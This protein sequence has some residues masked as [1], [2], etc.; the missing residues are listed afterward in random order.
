MLEQKAS[1]EDQ[2]AR[3][4]GG[5][6]G[7]G[8]LLVGKSLEKEA[9]R[10]LGDEGLPSKLP[11]WGGWACG[12]QSPE[13]SGPPGRTARPGSRSWAL[14]LVLQSVQVGFQV[15][16]DQRGVGGPPEAR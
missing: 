5:L 2:G 15:A 13:V 3:E 12:G 16:S 8:A 14:G 7:R 1:V 4:D 9:S 6:E 11:V 10:P